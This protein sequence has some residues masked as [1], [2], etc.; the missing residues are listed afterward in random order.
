MRR[1]WK[2]LHV[3]PMRHPLPPAL[4]GLGVC[5]VANPS[6]LRA[7]GPDAKTRQRH[8][9][10]LKASGVIRRHAE[11]LGIDK[12]L[13]VTVYGWEPHRLS[14]SKPSIS[15]ATGAATAASHTRAW[16]VAWLMS[17]STYRTV[18]VRRTTAPT[19]SGA[20]RTATERKV[21]CPPRL[22]RPTGRCGTS[23]AKSK[24]SPFGI[25]GILFLDELDESA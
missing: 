18:I 6:A 21:P 8:R 1:Y 17:P 3:H 19:R 16:D 15:T 24:R 5:L 7:S 25:Q 23:G 10:A 22:L 12:E 13:L 14:P 4:G 11:R 2:R 20:A 9:R